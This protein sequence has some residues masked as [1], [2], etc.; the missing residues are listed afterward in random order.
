MTPTQI[1]RESLPSTY[2]GVISDLDLVSVIMI[3]RGSIS[4]IASRGNLPETLTQTECVTYG[5]ESKK[6]MNTVS[7]I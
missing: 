6:D 3:D 5:V 7:Y 2:S 4:E 1:N